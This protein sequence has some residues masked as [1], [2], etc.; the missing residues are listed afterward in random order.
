MTHNNSETNSKVPKVAVVAVQ[1]VSD[2]KPF[3]SAIAIADAQPI[4][5]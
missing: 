4:T 1:G 5:D 2:Q 3:K